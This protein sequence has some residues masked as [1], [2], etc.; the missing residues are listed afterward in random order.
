MFS[1]IPEKL[2]RLSMHFKIQK[3][4]MCTNSNNCWHKET[5]EGKQPYKRANLWEL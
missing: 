1:I 2:Q 5:Q 3:A 4:P